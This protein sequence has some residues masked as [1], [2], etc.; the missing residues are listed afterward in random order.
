MITP[1]PAVYAGPGADATISVDAELL[2]SFSK[3]VLVQLQGIGSDIS[4]I[5]STLDEL[6]LGWAG[7]T[8]DEAKDF[9]DRLQAC[10][11]VLYGKDGD[12]GSEQNSMLGRVAGALDSAGNN[13]LA[14]ED[15]IVDLFYFTG[16]VSDTAIWNTH[17]GVGGG[18]G[19]GSTDITDP[20]FTSIAETF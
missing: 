8:A 14:A 10:L 20:K 9:F 17:N 16:S 11:T 2:L 5:F 3:Q 6:Q 15:A 18:S 19:G 13:Y 12:Q 1:A 4:T 7:Q